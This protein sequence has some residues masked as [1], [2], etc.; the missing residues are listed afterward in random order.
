MPDQTIN[1][2]DAE[3]RLCVVELLRWLVGDPESNYTMSE[4]AERDAHSV[5]AALSTPSGGEG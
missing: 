1:L 5:L 2:L 4:D 3:M